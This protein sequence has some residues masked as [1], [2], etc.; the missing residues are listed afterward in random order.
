MKDTPAR[1][2]LTLIV[3]GA[4][5]VCILMFAATGP[6][7]GQC[8]TTVDPAAGDVL[9]LEDLRIFRLDAASG[10]V[11][12]IGADVPLIALTV[13]RD[14]VLYG[15]GPTGDTLYAIRPAEGGPADAIALVP[16]LAT[17]VDLTVTEAG[18][19]AV[20]EHDPATQSA[21]VSLADPLTGVVQC[22]AGCLTPGS[23]ARDDPQPDDPGTV[24]Y[25]ARDGAVPTG[26]A[27]APG[28]DLLV[29]QVGADFLDIIRIAPD[30]TQTGYEV[31][32]PDISMPTS[33]AVAALPSGQ[34]F[35]VT[36]IGQF[37]RYDFDTDVVDLLGNLSTS[38][39][40]VDV[41]ASGVRHVFVVC[42]GLHEVTWLA[43]CDGL[44]AANVNGVPAAAA[45]VIVYP[46][47][48]L[49]DDTLAAFDF[50]TCAQLQN[51]IHVDLHGGNGAVEIV[52]LGAD[53]HALSMSSGATG[54]TIQQET[55]TSVVF[56][57]HVPT[58]G[59]W[60]AVDYRFFDRCA[61]IDV[62][63]NGRRACGISPPPTGA[64]GGP[65]ASRMAHF[66]RHINL[67][68]LGLLG[69]PR[70]VVELRLRSTLA[71]DGSVLTVDALLD[72]LI[73]T[74]SPCGQI[75]GDLNDDTI[76]DLCDVQYLTENYGGD[77]P[78]NDLNQDGYVDSFDFAKLLQLVERDYL[79]LC[80]PPTWRG[81]R[82]VPEDHTTPLMPGNLLIV[83]KDTDWED[84]IYEVD[85]LTLTALRKFRTPNSAAWPPVYTQLRHDGHGVLYA[86]DFNGSVERWQNVDG[87]LTWTPVEFAPPRVS[88]DG[89][90]PVD[91]AASRGAGLWVN[92]APKALAPELPDLSR[93]V[94]YGVEWEWVS[95]YTDDVFT[96]A[97]TLLIAG[98]GTVWAVT[99]D[100]IN[101]AFDLL[102]CLA[103]PVVTTHAVSHVD[104]IASTDL[105]CNSFYLNVGSS[106]SSVLSTYLVTGG[107]QRVVGP[108][109]TTTE[110]TDFTAVT[111]AVEDAVSGVTYVCGFK[112]VVEPQPWHMEPR[113]ARLP[114][115][116]GVPQVLSI[117][118]A[119]N[120]LNMP[121]GLA[122]Y[123]PAP[124]GDFDADY[125]VDIHD[126]VDFQLCFGTLTPWCRDD[127]DF[128]ADVDVDIDDFDL[129]STAL[130][131][132]QVLV[133]GSE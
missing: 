1:L 38:A 103:E 125:D 76:L 116:G 18:L 73:L 89:L 48:V 12:C 85:L 60:F 25:L 67:D 83:A 114:P 84:W 28:G 112:N 63:I 57:S 119:P 106:D 128:D 68:R 71:L 104:A 80:D 49:A 102:T 9:V 47:P 11:D 75:F 77:D 13:A 130:C 131:G 32:G 121:V 58:S 8:L 39:A 44:T 6:A 118:C 110:L 92:Y 98:V 86:V 70:I 23:G 78:C 129:F 99:A 21:R 2:Q 27:M 26:I 54:T 126:A 66:S 109:D 59:I 33:A 53:N 4:V 5:G 90:A 87:V 36:S 3:M 43:D 133:G 94:H 20:L 124:P 29:V 34:A 115:G 61:R 10:L 46:G 72:D 14:G 62:L 95:S 91:V 74:S 37:I 35:L 41:A 105:S 7:R 82:A 19:V 107:M 123:R 69:T 50:D 96:R 65:S 40:A 64:P 120:E 81:L 55:P 97:R 42:N 79:G 51:D 17:P 93:L 24:N 45:S 31:A 16:A 56:E 122:F 30:G 113:L 108:P 15:L 88:L 52:P 132:P 127:F 111:G 101:F 22:L 100:R 117:S